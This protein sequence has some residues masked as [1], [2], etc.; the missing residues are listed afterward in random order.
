MMLRILI[1]LAV[2]LFLISCK[3]G[4][5]GTSGK[6]NEE[7][8]SVSDVQV[9]IDIGDRAPEL[10][11]DSPDGEKIALSSLRGKMV[12]IDFWAAWCS[13]CR[14]ENPNLVR[15]YH[16]FKNKEFVNGTGFTVYGV[17]LD[18]RME[19]WVG[20]IEKDSLVWE[21][22]VS[23]LKGWQSVPAAMY[24]VMG[25]PMNFLI[26][27]DGIIVAKGLRGEYLNNKLKE[28]LTE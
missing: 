24:Q 2:S 14:L 18:R 15:T 17:S 11:F 8:S 9:G 26:D 25:I 28:L 22:H 21:T 13:P 5:A 1:L 4:N 3:S 16:E 7:L 19:D 23:D 6:E 20:A 12:L 10:N 27:G